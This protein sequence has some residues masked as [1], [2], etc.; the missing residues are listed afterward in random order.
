[1]IAACAGI[2][3]AQSS[4]TAIAAKRIRMIL[5]SSLKQKMGERSSQFSPLFE[6]ALVLVRLNH[7][8]GLIVNANHSIM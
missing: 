2:A 6:I 3:I 5:A 8:T 7:V 4:S 1:M